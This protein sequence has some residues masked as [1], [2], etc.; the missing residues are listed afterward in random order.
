MGENLASGYTSVT[1]AVDMWYNEVEVYKMNPGGF[2]QGTGHF[3]QVSAK[4][5]TYNFRKLNKPNNEK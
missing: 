5:L 2:Q 3:T 1:Q 4:L